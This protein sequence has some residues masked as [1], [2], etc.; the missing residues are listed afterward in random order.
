[1][2]TQTNQKIKS[3]TDL[4]VW[5]EG[6]K[7]VLQIYD[8]THTFPDDERFSLTDQLRRAVISITSNIAEGFSRHTN[9]D[10]RSF[11]YKALG[12]VTET[13]NQLLI[14]RDLQYIT[15][16]NFNERAHVSTSVAKLLNGLIKSTR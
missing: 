8:I 11:Y 1:M 5:K 13:Q 15:H 14:A 16:R 9:R 6:H 12:S 3:F 7:L 4:N 2:E 10:K